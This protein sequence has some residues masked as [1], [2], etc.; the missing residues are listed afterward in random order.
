MHPWADCVV[1]ETLTGLEKGGTIT[2]LS[3]DLDSGWK[4]AGK[5]V[6]GFDVGFV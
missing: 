6:T 4:F 3:G 2:E 5:A 1:S